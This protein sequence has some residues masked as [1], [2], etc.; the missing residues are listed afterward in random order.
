MNDNQNTLST[1]EPLADHHQTDGFDCGK[2]SSLTEWLKRFALSSQKANSSRTYVIHRDNKVVG[3]YALCAASV[4]QEEA[5]QR[6]RK[7]LPKQPIPAILL[8]RLAVDKNYQKQGIGPNL[9][10]DALAR[11]LSAAK[12]IGARVVLV[13]AIDEEAKRFYKH[14]GFEDSPIDDLHLML[15]MKDIEKSLLPK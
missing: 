14:W 3:Y 9:L 12:E 10:R 11:C 4:S 6:T 7:G 5:T 13:H 1:I 2:H 15:L 8:A